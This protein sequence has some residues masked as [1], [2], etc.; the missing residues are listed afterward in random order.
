MK[1]G[2]INFQYVDNVVAVKRFHYRGVTMA[3]TYLEECNQVS[4]ITHRVKGQSGKISIPCSDI[5][6]DSNS[7]MG[8][9]DLF[10]Q[11]ISAYKL[12]RKSSGGR[13]YIRLFFDLMDISVVNSHVP[14]GN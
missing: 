6:K 11:K 5:F 7:G 2:D 14:K 9:V 8:G 13:Y 10:N 3:G 12:D 4:T 1:R